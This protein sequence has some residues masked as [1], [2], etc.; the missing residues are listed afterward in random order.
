MLG[1]VDDWAETVETMQNRGFVLAHNTI[2]RTSLEYRGSPGI[3]AG[4]VRDTIIEHNE[5]SH[6]SY[7]GVSIVSVA[8][9]LAW[10]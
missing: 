5:I 10:S 4:Y 7:S 8:P 2:S 1:Q 6:L 3:T 9:L